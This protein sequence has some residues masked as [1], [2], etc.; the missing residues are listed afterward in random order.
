M[1]RKLENNAGYGKT[2]EQAGWF[3]KWRNNEETLREEASARAHEICRYTKDG[4]R[5]EKHR[6]REHA[7]H[8]AS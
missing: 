4:G 7:L 1:S 6:Q 8:K 2:L 3:M 5:R